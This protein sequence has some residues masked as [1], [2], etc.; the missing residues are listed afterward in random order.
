MPEKTAEIVRFQDISVCYGPGCR[1]VVFFSDTPVHCGKETSCNVYTAEKLMNKLQENSDSWGFEGGVTFSGGETAGYQEFLINMLKRCHLLGIETAVELTG[2][3]SEEFFCNIMGL[4]DFVFIT[5]KSEIDNYKQGLI[6]DL[7]LKNISNIKN[8]KWKGRLVIRHVIE[9]NTDD[10]VLGDTK[11]IINLMRANSLQEVNVVTRAMLMDMVCGEK[12]K[13][14]T[15]KENSETNR[16]L[17]DNIDKIKSMYDDN[18]IMC[19]IGD[20][21]PY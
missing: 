9:E 18:Y 15:D 1:S 17:D 4:V 11:R 14:W 12:L 21:T 13:F 3:V 20:R 5:V 2:D 10:L 8:N 19:Y 6:S 16:S 7:S